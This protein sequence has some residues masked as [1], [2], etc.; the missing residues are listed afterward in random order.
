MK[1]CP[2]CSRKYEDETLVFCLDDGSRLAQGR[3]P[4]ATWHLPEQPVNESRRSGPVPPTTP[5][6][7]A[8][9]TA[10]PEHFQALPQ[11]PAPP[12]TYSEERSRSSA[13]PWILGIVVILG[14]SGVLIAWIVTR[15]PSERVAV[16]Y[17]SP[18]PTVEVMRSPDTYR[19]PETTVT[20]TPIANPT[21][22][23]EKRPKPT[24]EPTAPPKKAAFS[25]L[26]NTSYS[27]GS[28]I[29]YYPRASVG[30][31]QADC[32]ANASC[33]AFTWIRPGAYNP[34]DSAMCYLMY[35]VTGPV[36]HPC[37]ISGVKN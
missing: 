4:Q 28:R 27:G 13:L 37:C 10:R 24:A 12:Q 32:A 30:G 14:I 15:G 21:A 26:N 9:I 25:M 16:I 31:C 36:S 18:T 33:R 7:P 22:K 17:P 29:T 19:T 6:P 20:P 34:G 3:D 5:S 23:D 35:S 8:T 2:T 1:I 11:Q